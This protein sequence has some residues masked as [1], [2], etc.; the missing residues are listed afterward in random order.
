ME[1]WFTG[2]RTV[3]NRTH[4]FYSDGR[5]SVDLACVLC[6]RYTEAIHRFVVSTNGLDN[7]RALSQPLD[8]RGEEEVANAY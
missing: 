7:R 2:T 5:T 1:H 6:Y 8:L 3:N 4:I